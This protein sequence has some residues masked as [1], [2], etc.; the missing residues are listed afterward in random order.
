[1]GLK[2]DKRIL[3]V[4]PDENNR[5]RTWLNIIV[6][7]FFGLAVAGSIALVLVYKILSIGLPK[8]DGLDDYRP[9]LV[10]QVHDRHGTLIGEFMYENQRRYL[11]G[12]DEIPE[13]V[14]QAFVSAEDQTFFTHEGVDYAGIMRAAWTNLWAGEIKQGGSTITQ[15]VVKSL[16]LTPAKTYRRKMREMILA[17]RIE[18]RLSK[19]EILYLYLNEVYFGAGAYGVQAA[20]REY[21]GKDVQQLDVAEG[22]LLAGL[23]RAP[24][25]YN[26]RRHPEQALARRH[27][28]LARLREDGHLA[29]EAFQKAD[30]APLDVVP[31]QEINLELA[32]HYVE[33]V[34][35]YLV[36][37][38][39][40]EAM[41]KN[42][43][44]VSTACD[45]KLQQAAQKA[46][47]LGLRLHAKRQGLL[48]LPPKTPPEKW[49]GKIRKLIMKN[50]GRGADE[51]QEGLVVSVDDARGFALVNLGERTIRLTRKQMDWV[52]AVRRNDKTK[53][54][55]VRRPGQVL[56]AGDRVL[57]YKF[58]DGPYVLAAWPVAEAALLSMDVNTREVLVMVGGKDYRQSQFNRAT[59][60]RRQPGSAFKPIVYAAALSAGLSP[61]SVFPDTALV[62]ANNWRP[63]NYDRK[64]RGYMSLREAL[65][66]SINTVTIR[67]AE[68]IGVDY[69]LRFARR[70]GMKSLTSGDLSMAIGTYELPPVE[71]IN[72]FAVFAAG[73][74]LADPVLV[75]K[76]TSAEGE[77]IEQYRISEFVEKLPPM[78]GVPDLRQFSPDDLPEGVPLEEEDLASTEQLAEFLS[79][80]QLTDTPTPTPAENL[81]SD[82]RGEVPLSVRTSGEVIRQQ[83]IDPQVA[84]VI[85][86]MMHSVATSGTGA[87]SN[88]LGRVVA[89]K[90]GT[91][92][93]YVD[94][95]FIGF[96]P[97]ILAGV[98]VGHDRGGR[99]MGR[100]ETGSSAAL[101][102]WI[103]FMSTAL[104]DLPNSSFAVPSGVVFARVD[105]ETG[106]L[107]RPEQEGREEC[108]VAG[109]EPT[110][111]APSSDVPS[112]G[113]FF[114]LDFMGGQ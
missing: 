18:D 91:T 64:F 60:A 12:I 28:V 16:M 79:D 21:F 71:L 109:T 54:V 4:E 37:K 13:L 33:G 24:S 81:P 67:V 77:V 5:L 80:F 42:G 50:V 7:S 88:A 87:R 56:G 103:D 11:V 96:S 45:L 111:Y 55:N 52:K 20:A 82:P 68:T 2:N 46:V 47:N 61:A 78:L 27:Y 101:P 69:I 40:A 110:E 26:P 34:R 107:A 48:A 38:Y 44:Q 10:T 19:K 76:V 9:N 39:G 83:V 58:K 95:W 3:L 36:A 41:L 85:T 53:A 98:W 102:I 31:H 8:I 94:A 104:A 22:A 97:Q 6:V 100:G 17:K 105:Q 93:D 15:Q 35:R 57:I 114:D 32:P 84:Y 30:D 90:T 1:M 23:L 86:S 108:F 51:I 43:L 99:T 113:D 70:L 66:R 59:Q 49:E 74:K 14:V 25:R 73:G 62:F 29:A 89:G 106:L 75:T 63:A 65:T 92:N 112:P 72:A